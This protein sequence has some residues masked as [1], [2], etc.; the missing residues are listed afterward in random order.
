MGH[1]RAPAGLQDMEV[2]AELGQELHSVETDVPSTCVS[3]KGGRAGDRKVGEKGAQRW[4][5]GGAG[6]VSRKCCSA[7]LTL[8]WFLET[9]TTRTYREQCW[10]RYG[11]ALPP[12][13]F[14]QWPCA[15][16]PDCQQQGCSDPSGGCERKWKQSRT[17][18]KLR[19]PY[20]FY[21]L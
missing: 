15:T 1:L 2:R 3:W 5:W 8:R 14:P 13:S 6:R 19:G 16:N 9:L 20:R 17:R 4:G 11:R 18:A 21:L 10:S 12:S 7:P